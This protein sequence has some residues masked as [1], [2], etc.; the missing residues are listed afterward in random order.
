MSSGGRPGAAAIV[1]VA[2]VVA[3]A[4]GGV[5]LLV[6][7]DSDNSAESSGGGATTAVPQIEG[8]ERQD[9]PSALENPFDESFPD[10]IVDP[11]EI[12]SGGPPPDGI[13]PIDEPTFQQADKVDWLDDKEPVL[14]VELD[15]DARAYPVQVMTWHEIVNDTI[16]DRPVTISYCPLCNSAIAYD[17]RVGDSVLDFGTSGSLLNSSLVM[18]DRQTESLWSH[19]TGQAIIGH[20]TGTQLE[21]IPMQTISWADFLRTSPD[22]LVLSRDTGFRRDYGFNPYPGYD[23]VDTSP[24]LFD[25]EVDGRLAAKT[26]VLGIRGETDSIAIVNDALY[27]RHVVAFTLDGRDAVALLIPGT[28]SGLETGRVRDGRDVGATGVYA[29]EVDGQS[30]TFTPNDDE[31][32]FTDDQTGSTWDITGEAIDGP[33]VGTRLEAIE[34][35]DTFWFALAAF[36]PDTEIVN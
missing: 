28:A 30:L 23:N 5:A 29:V 31:V 3:S 8:D 2:L 6:S 13:P 19:F 10:P 14:V 27:E 11:N 22:G 16:G 21:L 1:I 36:N 33:L 9:V 24:F 26:K 4:V 7:G 34:H 25:G 20:L 12:R 15:G 35:V 18:Y 17:R 32:T